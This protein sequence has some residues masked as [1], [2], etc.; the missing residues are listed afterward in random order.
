M[1]LPRLP[2]CGQELTIIRG[3]LEEGHGSC[4]Q[5]EFVIF[6]GISSTEHDDWASSRGSPRSRIIRSG[7]FFWAKVRPETASEAQISRFLSIEQP[8]P[9]EDVDRRR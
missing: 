7:V 5:N 9:G 1:L 8:S 2:N 4:L 3:L 6:D